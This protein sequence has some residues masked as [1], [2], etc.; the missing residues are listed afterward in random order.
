MAF[1]NFILF[2]IIKYSNYKIF[3]FFMDNI[4][5]KGLEITNKYYMYK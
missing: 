5:R 4:R 3:I 2:E 1:L